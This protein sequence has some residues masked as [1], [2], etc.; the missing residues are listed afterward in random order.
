MQV[1]P[2]ENLVPQPK[3][4]LKIDYSYLNIPFISF[5]ISIATCLC[6]V[7]FYLQMSL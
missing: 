1:Y 4:A 5:N 6:T 3:Y 7:E 2:S